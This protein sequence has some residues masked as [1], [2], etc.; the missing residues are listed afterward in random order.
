MA[1]SSNPK[2]GNATADALGG[3]QTEPPWVTEP[4]ET[5][6]LQY[7]RPERF[8]FSPNELSKQVI[9]QSEMLC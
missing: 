8:A 7:R 3:A 4:V 2:I 1:K 6:P 9:E 5:S